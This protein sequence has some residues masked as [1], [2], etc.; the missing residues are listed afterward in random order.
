MILFF[1]SLLIGVVV[2][3]S[4]QSL[5]ISVSLMHLSDP[6]AVKILRTSNQMIRNDIKIWYIPQFT[7][8]ALKIRSF[9]QILYETPE[10]LFAST[11][12][13]FSNKKFLG[14]TKILCQNFY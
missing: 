3:S 4:Q 9:Y 12:F 8:F 13:F 6:S 11:D 1:F 10:S 7:L 2:N 14:F 5:Y